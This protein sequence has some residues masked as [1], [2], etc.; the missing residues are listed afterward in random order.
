M[1]SKIVTVGARLA[2][3]VNFPSIE[4]LEGSEV[5]VGGIVDFG[6]EGGQSSGLDGEG[7]PADLD[8]DSFLAF[9]SKV[10]K[11][12]GSFVNVPELVKGTAEHGVQVPVDGRA[13]NSETAEDVS[14]DRVVNVEQDS[15]AGA[16][17]III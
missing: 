9:F 10:R 13:V 8:P 16:N 15:D 17:S 1:G 5:G 6:I 3:E 14:G 4:V 12:L 7:F 2:G 11:S